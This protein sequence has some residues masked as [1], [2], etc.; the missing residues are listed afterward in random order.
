MTTVLSEALL[1]EFSL[2]IAKEIGL[3]FPEQKWGDLER[4]IHAA[5]Q[6]FQFEDME[7]CITWL[8]SSSLSQKQALVYKV[9]CSFGFRH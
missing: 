3:F 8:M 7:A 2:F 9:N 4:G 6:A 5:A 1:S